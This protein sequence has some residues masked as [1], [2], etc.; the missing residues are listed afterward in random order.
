VKRFFESMARYFA[1]CGQ[2]VSAADV[3]AEYRRNFER[4]IKPWLVQQRWPVPET[5]E[6]KSVCLDLTCNPF[7]IR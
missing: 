5:D 6:G 2:A 3:A 4:R 7:A 1:G